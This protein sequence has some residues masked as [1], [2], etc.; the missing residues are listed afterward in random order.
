MRPT[1][2]IT[3]LPPL[4][5]D[6]TRRRVRVTVSPA[7]QYMIRGWFV[8]SPTDASQESATGPA[9]P[10]AE[11]YKV[12]N[13]LGTCDVEVNSPNAFGAYCAV[14]V[15]GL[16]ASSNPASL[17]SLPSA[18]AFGAVEIGSYSDKVFTVTNA[19]AVPLS[20]VASASAPFSITGTAT[21]T[22]APSA[23]ASVTVRY[24]PSAEESSAGVIT[25]TGG[26]GSSRPVT[27]T[28]YVSASG[29][30]VM[31]APS[32]SLITDETGFAAWIA[33]LASGKTADPVEGGQYALSVDPPP[34]VTNLVIA[35][36]ASI[37]ALNSVVQTGTGAQVRLSWVNGQYNLFTWSGIPY[38]VYQNITLF[39]WTEPETFTITL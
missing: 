37:R 39:P 24:T 8:T 2:T 3:I 35:Y 14:T 38:R 4:L 13:A 22:L 27:G 19:G 30:F 17:W 20:G 34:D 10:G 32:D 15:M 6:P 7:G 25:F 9:I 16:V 31:Y 23:S 33:A 36:P 21:Y 26:T 1:A 29:A 11:F 28:G 12:T 5:A 18:W